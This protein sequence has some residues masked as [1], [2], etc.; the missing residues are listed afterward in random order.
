MKEKRRKKSKR[1]RQALHPQPQ[2]SSH[3][4]N[5]LVAVLAV[6]VAA[7][8]I[9]HLVNI[10]SARV[11]G[12][13]R[14]S[15]TT[16]APGATGAPNEDAPPFHVDPESAKP[17]PATQDP[18]RFPIPFVARAYAIAREMPEVLA[19]Q[20]C[21]CHC[22]GFGHGSLLDCFASDHGAACTA[23]LKEAFLAEQMTKSERTPQEIRETIMKGLWRLVEL[24]SL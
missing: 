17:F 2:G 10:T 6:A 4:S 12:E 1:Q 22:E 13:P 3:R 11:P 7:F 9:Y 24:E 16:A 18:S 15:T 21:Y 8:F 23:C 5:V 19:Q 20:P 14:D